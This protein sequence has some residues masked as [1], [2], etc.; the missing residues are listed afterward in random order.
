MNESEDPK[1]TKS[2]EIMKNPNR[3][4]KKTIHS[5]PPLNADENTIFYLCKIYLVSRP[6][7]SFLP[8][9]SLQRARPMSGDNS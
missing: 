8:S 7:V 1:I 2:N 4:E 6:S 3:E 5:K 9:R